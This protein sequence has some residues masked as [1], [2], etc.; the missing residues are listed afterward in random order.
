[1]PAADVDPAHDLHVHSVVLKDEGMGARALRR[2]RVTGLRVRR[3]HDQNPIPARGASKRPAL[4]TVGGQVLR[5]LLTPNP[6]TA[7]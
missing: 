4:S 1:V 6:M 5:A 2:P 3:Q 7:V